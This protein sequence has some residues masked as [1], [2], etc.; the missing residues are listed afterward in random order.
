AIY[1]AGQRLAFPGCWEKH[2]HYFPSPWASWIFQEGLAFD[3]PG[4]SKGQ[5]RGCL[6]AE[7]RANAARQIHDLENLDEE[8]D[9]GHGSEDHDSAGGVDMVSQ[10]LLRG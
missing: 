2:C 8:Q 9:G 10:D 7:D 1:G 3:E 5:E 6:E 4:G